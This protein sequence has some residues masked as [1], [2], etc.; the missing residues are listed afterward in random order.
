MQGDNKSKK[1]KLIYNGYQLTKLY[2]Y[3]MFMQPHNFTHLKL[4]AELLGTA[5]TCKMQRVTCI[6]VFINEKSLTPRSRV[7]PVSQPP[8]SILSQMN[9]VHIL[10]PDLTHSLPGRGKLLR[11]SATA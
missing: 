11:N 1:D 6:Q 4:A 10:T 9:P 5:L 8:I 2:W 7:L 3:C